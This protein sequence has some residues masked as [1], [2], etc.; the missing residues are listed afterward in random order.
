MYLSHEGCRFPEGSDSLCTPQIVAKTMSLNWYRTTAEWHAKTQNGVT[1]GHYVSGSKGLW[2]AREAA[3]TIL[4]VRWTRSH[5][6]K[7]N[8]T[9]RKTVQEMEPRPNNPNSRKQ[10][11]GILLCCPRTDLV[12]AM[13]VLYSESNPIHHLISIW[14]IL[15]KAANER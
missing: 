10:T 3:W 7:V 15:L 1:T 8:D 13:T 2:T 4:K 6:Q 9:C 5:M 12:K 11:V 14:I